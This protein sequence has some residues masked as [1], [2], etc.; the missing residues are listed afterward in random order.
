MN[1]PF[2]LIKEKIRLYHIRNKHKTT[3]IGP[4]YVV[5]DI[6][7][8]CNLNCIACWT[9]SPYLTKSKPLP[10]W[11]KEQLEFKLMMHLVHDLKRLG[12]EEI[13]L[14]GGGEPFMHPDIFKIIHLIK[15]NRIKLS[16]TTNVTLLNKKKIDY[17]AKEKV[18]NLTISLWASNEQD[19]LA[20]HPNQPKGAFGR[21]CENLAYLT[22]KIKWTVFSNVISNKNHGSICEMAGFASS[23]N[24]SEIYFTLVDSIDGETDRLLLNE[25]ERNKAVIS[26][27]EVMA[28]YSLGAYGKMKIDN[29]E[30]FLRRLETPGMTEGNYDNVYL[31]MPCTIGYTFSRIM[32]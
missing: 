22:G 27:K 3:L 18:D 11:F 8:R 24:A 6:T 7:N 10:G 25:K 1:N 28:K 16:I 5:I 9:Y 30:N 21:I 15:S 29:P 2:S 12:V 14:T 4:K 23:M 20:T 31:K 19:Y 26:F 17:L 32:A 13:R